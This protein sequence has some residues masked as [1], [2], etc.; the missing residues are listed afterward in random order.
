MGW[1]PMRAAESHE[2][3]CQNTAKRWVATGGTDD[4]ER[5]RE[6]CLTLVDYFTE[7]LTEYDDILVDSLVPTF[8]PLS[9]VLWCG[10]IGL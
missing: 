9:E 6:T 5:G 7:T 1:D 8:F 10:L 3:D 4:Y 2:R